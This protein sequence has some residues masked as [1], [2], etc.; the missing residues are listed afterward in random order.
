VSDQLK[1][2]FKAISVATALLTSKFLPDKSKIFIV[3]FLDRIA[4][5][6]L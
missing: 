4:A 3:G 2:E 5:K 1:S 6:I